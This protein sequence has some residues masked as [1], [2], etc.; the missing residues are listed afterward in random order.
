MIKYGSIEI[1]L[2]EG[3]K[4]RREKKTKGK[5]TCKWNGE[6]RKEVGRE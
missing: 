4:I 1:K 6:R 3:R 2:Q 5:C